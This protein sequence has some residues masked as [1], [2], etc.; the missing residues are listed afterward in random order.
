[1]CRYTHM[2]RIALEFQETPRLRFMQSLD[3]YLLSTCI[4]HTIPHG[5]CHQV[6]AQATWGVTSH[7]IQNRQSYRF[8]YMLSYHQEFGLP[9]DKGC[10]CVCQTFLL[11]LFIFG[12]S[13]CIN[14][15]ALRGGK[16][17]FACFSHYHSS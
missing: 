1:M 10:L 7:F 15:E 6:Q 5:C 3:K 12:P 8:Y 11:P 14:W 4:V 17:H 9:S 13:L 2:Q 16:H